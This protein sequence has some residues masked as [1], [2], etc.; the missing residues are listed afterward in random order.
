MMITCL[1]LSLQSSMTSPP[2]SE[3][4]WTIHRDW[5]RRNDRQL[6]KDGKISAEQY[7]H[8]LEAIITAA[9]LMEDNDK[10]GMD[11]PTSDYQIPWHTIDTQLLPDV[12][13]K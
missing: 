12:S 13:E 5:R 11:Y 4:S 1:N 8:I 10:K 3:A 6:Y 7:P 9:S 2:P